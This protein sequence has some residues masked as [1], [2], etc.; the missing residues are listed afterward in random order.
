VRWQGYGAADDTWELRA[1]LMETVSTLVLQMDATKDAAAKDGKRKTQNPKSVALGQNAHARAAVQQEQERAIWRGLEVT[2]SSNKGGA[3]VRWRVIGS[4]GTKSTMQV[5]RLNAGGA[6]VQQIE[7]DPCCSP[8][9]N[10]LPLI[11]K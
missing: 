6:Q 1:S 7:G 9:S 3:G 4:G 11:L 2:L 10:S 5:Q 8:L